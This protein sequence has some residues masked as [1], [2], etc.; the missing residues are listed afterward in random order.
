M[1]V[2]KV[3]QG[4]VTEVIEAVQWAVSGD[5][6]EAAAET[7]RRARLVGPDCIAFLSFVMR[8]DGFASAVQRVRCASLL[9]ETGEFV[10]SAAKEPTGL[11]REAEDADGVAARAAS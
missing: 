10:A 4:K 1:A 9:L 3:A 2:P 7:R 11:F 5:D 6:V 8:T